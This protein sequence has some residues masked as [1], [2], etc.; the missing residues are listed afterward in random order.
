MKLF[1]APPLSKTLKIDFIKLLR[2]EQ[3]VQIHDIGARVSSDQMIGSI[4]KLPVEIVTIRV[5]QNLSQFVQ[6][7]ATQIG[8]D[9]RA[10]AKGTR[11]ICGSIDAIGARA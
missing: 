4:L 10:I 11:S 8:I 3:E 2:H 1:A 6:C 9:H 5:A 7:M